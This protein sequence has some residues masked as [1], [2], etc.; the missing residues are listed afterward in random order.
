MHRLAERWH[1][2]PVQI[3]FVHIG[4]GEKQ[5]AL[6]LLESAYEQRSWELVFLQVVPWLDDLR[7]EPRFLE[8]VKKMNFPK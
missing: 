1:V 4:L 5:Q 8:L 3:A 2:P 6:D 7:A